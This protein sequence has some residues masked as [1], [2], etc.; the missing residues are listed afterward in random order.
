MSNA[1]PLPCTAAP[2]PA[3]SE[4]CPDQ[5][6]TLIACVIGSSLAFVLGSIVNVA[7]PQMQASF[8]A[9]ATGA[10][11]IVNAY[12]LPLGALV[13]TGGAL[14]DHYGRKRLFQWGLAIFTASCLLCAVA[15]SFP[16]LLAA[17]ALEGV[18][19]AMIA[20]TSLAIIADAFTGKARGRAV[21]T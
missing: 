21:G 19:A 3:A 1:L 11:W 18:G 17:R 9:G 4:D 14:G 13:L 20:P 15:W 7:L 16:V 6:G 5:R 8:D 12:L 2:G 10:Q